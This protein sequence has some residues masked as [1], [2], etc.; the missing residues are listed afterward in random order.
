MSLPHKIKLDYLNYLCCTRYNV[1]GLTP[2]IMDKHKL[3]VVDLH[4]LF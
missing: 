4:T 3:N 2:I 1:V